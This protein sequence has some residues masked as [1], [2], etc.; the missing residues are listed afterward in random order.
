V[1][2]RAGLNPTDWTLH[3]FRRTCITAWL[4]AGLDVRTLMALAGHSQI[5]STMRHLRP[6]KAKR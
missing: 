5:E 2:A 1:A 3:G 4:R 6:Q